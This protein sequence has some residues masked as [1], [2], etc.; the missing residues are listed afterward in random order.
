MYEMEIVLNML[1]DAIFK[2]I[3]CYICALVVTYD[4]WPTTHFIYFTERGVVG[5]NIGIA[6]TILKIVRE[7]PLLR[8]EMKVF[9]SNVLWMF[10]LIVS[11]SIPVHNLLDHLL[12]L[13]IILYICS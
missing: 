2:R 4:N 8:Q 7:M 6:F 1:L 5:Y 13:I 12:I 3:S 11:N 9:I 10:W